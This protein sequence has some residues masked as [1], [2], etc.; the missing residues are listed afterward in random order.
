MQ[1]STCGILV[2]IETGAA[3]TLYGIVIATFW[4]GVFAVLWPSPTLT[5]NL[6]QSSLNYCVIL[7]MLGALSL[8]L[9]MTSES[10]VSQRL[11]EVR[12]RC[13]ETCCNNSAPY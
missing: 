9:D 5:E 12:E 1:V 6:V 3:Q 13:Y 4:F 7:I 2:F 8:K 10:I 11:V